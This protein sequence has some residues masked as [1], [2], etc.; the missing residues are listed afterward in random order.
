MSGRY[1]FKNQTHQQLLTSIF[2]QHMIKRIL[3]HVFLFFALD[4]FNWQKKIVVKTS[5]IWY[6]IYIVE[7]VVALLSSDLNKKYVLYEFLPN[8]KVNS[9]FITIIFWCQVVE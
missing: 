4:I 6:T 8:I 2:L 7:N 1:H 5:L 9:F 3:L